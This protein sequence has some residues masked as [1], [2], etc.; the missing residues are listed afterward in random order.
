[1]PFAPRTHK[2]N[3]SDTVPAIS[4]ARPYAQLFAN[5]HLTVDDRTRPPSVRGWIA[6]HSSLSWDCGYF[7]WAAKNLSGAFPLPTEE[8]CPKGAVIGALFLSEVLPPGQ[9]PAGLPVWRRPH[10]G[11]AGDP[12]GLFHGFHGLVFTSRFPAPEPIPVRGM[13][14]TFRIPKPCWWDSL[15]KNPERMPPS[16]AG[17]TKWPNP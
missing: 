8:E 15:P 2:P 1:M 12:S 6:L 5:G 9:N 4:M 11:G 14:G 3:H 13:P 7:H 16:A 17:E 10:L